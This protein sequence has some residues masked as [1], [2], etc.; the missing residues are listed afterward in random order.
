MS[1]ILH[2]P[3]KWNVRLCLHFQSPTKGIIYKWSVNLNSLSLC[4]ISSARGQLNKWEKSPQSSSPSPTRVWSSSM[5]PIRR[6]ARILLMSLHTLTVNFQ[7]SAVCEI[8]SHIIYLSCQ[9]F[10]MFV[11]PNQEQI[12]SY[13]H[14]EKL[15][16]NLSP[17]LLSL[18][19]LCFR[20]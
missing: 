20:F 4:A 3:N 7:K 6:G 13:W 10:F 15:H 14:L 9:M 17:V 16:T 19:L 11:F 8:T 5:Q 2:K 18:A 1:S 12:H